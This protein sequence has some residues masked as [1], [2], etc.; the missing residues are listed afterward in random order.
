MSRANIARI[1][2]DGSAQ[3]IYLHYGEPL[4]YGSILLERYQTDAD[5]QSLL[6]LGDLSSVGPII[7][8]RVDFRA[9]VGPNSLN[10]TQCLAFHRD[11]NDPWERC[12]P[13]DTTGGLDGFRQ[14]SDQGSEWLY[15]YTPDGWASWLY[16]PDNRWGS[17]PDAILA[18]MSGRLTTFGKGVQNGLLPPSVLEGLVEDFA[19]K[20]DRLWQTPA[21][22]QLL[23]QA[24]S[25]G[26][27]GD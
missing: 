23:A 1:R 13:R 6:D 22:R 21:I 11:R 17:I 20:T 3:F 5:V 7:G 19:A 12:Q 8:N 27:A 9:R 10:P 15:A 2:P 25:Q 4:E 14:A 24:V 18:D 26:Q 16:E